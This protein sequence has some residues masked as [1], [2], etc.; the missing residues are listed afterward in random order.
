MLRKITK[1]QADSGASPGTGAPAASDEGLGVSWLKNTL[2]SVAPDLSSAAPSRS[3]GGLGRGLANC[4]AGDGEDPEGAGL[5]SLASLSGVLGEVSLGGGSA[6]ARNMQ[7]LIK[8]IETV[9]ADQHAAVDHRA[10]AVCGG[11]QSLCLALVGVRALSLSLR[12]LSVSRNEPKNPCA[13][14]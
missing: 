5:L 4:G 12:S 2:G 3:T 8:D 6:E 10:N 9:V 11:G 7:Q 14:I 1:L 13:L